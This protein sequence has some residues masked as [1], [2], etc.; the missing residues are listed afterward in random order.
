V[1]QYS[2]INGNWRDVKWNTETYDV[3]V[4]G[5]ILHSEGEKL[6]QKLIEQS[7]AAMKC[8]PLLASQKHIVCQLK[9][10]PVHQL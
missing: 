9:K 10:C 3:V 5:H 1:N 7:F 8:F 4:L 6:S 2:Y